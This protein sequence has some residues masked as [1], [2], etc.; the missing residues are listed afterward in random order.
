LHF[1]FIKFYFMNKYRPVVLVILDGW[2]EWDT[3]VGNPL[4]Y[5][6]LPTFKQ[7]DAHYPKLLLEASGLAVGLPWGVFGNSEVGH[8]TIG[9]GQIIYHYL[10]TI[11]AAI[12]SRSFFSNPALLSAVQWAKSNN[13]SLHL[14]GLYS[15]GGV[16]SHIDHLFALLELAKEQGLTKVYL[17]AVTDGRDTPTQAGVKML[18]RTQ[19]AIRQIGVGQIATIAGRYFTMDRNRN[20]DRLEK[21]FKAYVKG[22][23]VFEKDPVEAVKKQYEQEIFDEYIEPIVMVGDDDKP[24]ATIN[25][26]DAI[27]NF[28]F[29]ADRARQISRVFALPGFDKFK[30][31]RV[32][33]NI[34]YVG[35]TQYE[36]EVPI[37]VAFPPQEITS[38]V[39]DILSQRKK[40]QLRI[41]EMEKFAHV[42]Y[43][44][45]GGL[46]EPFKG[47]ERVFVPSKNAKSYADVPEMSA[48][49][50]TEKLLGAIETDEY[51]FVLVNYANAD[52]VGHTGVF[53]AGVKAVE[54]VDE[55]L[56]QLINM[57]LS[58]NG[59][60]LI[61]AD[62]G[63]IE[64]MVNLQTGQIDT[65]HSVN[66][67]PFWYVNA[68]NKKQKP[69]ASAP[70][71]V[72]GM[73]ADIAPTILEL[74]N[75]GR[76]D[77][78]IGDSLLSKLKK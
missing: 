33:R 65:Q 73:I 3:K 76:P 18:Q 38:R 54:V 45:N 44:F 12:Q 70:L 27:I 55:C 6:N 68:R 66:P 1:D 71:E 4:A 61:T 48:H 36:K 35:F 53:K 28:N 64:E 34:K 31:V 10:P 11:S 17:H 16:H 57:V 37:E 74:F 30:E 20:W 13:S 8:Q 75:I 7:L 46:S 40:K 50:I 58:I 59:C 2:G 26:N 67:V 24:I 29:R 19:E 47:E 52:M 56:S 72:S 41:A 9:S 14:I 25:E 32:P 63:N 43:F 5:A 39:A 60:L 77:D 62:H 78:M 15:D 51:D 69:I 42:T 21:S 22:R 23:G 49:Q